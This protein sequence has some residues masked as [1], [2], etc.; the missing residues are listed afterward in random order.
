MRFSPRVL[1]SLGIAGLMLNSTQAQQGLPVSAGSS[2]FAKVG[3][4]FYVQGGA[5]SADNLVPQFFAIDLT[6]SWPA[7]QPSWKSL[8]PGPSNAYHSAGYSADGST[9]FTFG[10]DTGAAVTIV[11]SS[12]LNI[13]NIN[14]GTWTSATPTGL[15]DSTRR[16][17]YAVTNPSANQIYIL[18][19][20]AGAG[21]TIVSNVFDTFNVASGTLTEIT[22]PPSGP[23]NAITYAANI[24]VCSQQYVSYMAQYSAYA[25]GSLVAVFGGFISAAVNAD[26]NAYI[27]NTKTWTWI[28]VPYSGT[29]RGNSAC[30]IVDDTFIIWG[31]YFNN[32]SQTN[33]VP[34]P[35]DALLLLSLST[36]QWLTTYT[37]STN[38]TGGSNSTSSGGSSGTAGGSISSPTNTGASSSKGV[39]TAVIGGIAAGVVVVLLAAAFLLH[40]RNK[41]KNDHVKDGVTNFEFSKDEEGRHEESATHDSYGRPRRPIPPPDELSPALYDFEDPPSPLT[42][43]AQRVSLKNQKEEQRLSI[44]PGYVHAMHQPLQNQNQ[45][46]SLQNQRQPLQNQ[47]QN[48][49]LQTS[50]QMDDAQYSQP[51]VEGYS[52]TVAGYSNYPTPSPV[53]HNAV[54]EP[55]DPLFG[56]ISPY[57]QQQARSYADNYANAGSVY[58]PPPPT[59]LSQQQPGYVKYSTDN[60]PT[61]KVPAE[62]S[63]PEASGYHDSYGMKHQSVYSDSSSNGKRPISGP[64]GG[65][66]FGSIYSPSLPGAPQSIPE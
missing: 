56:G 25:D 15:A 38:M 63:D 16:D 66:G 49:Y 13:F 5:S 26:P 11:P 12:W 35:A 50:P 20:D 54:E 37:P 3:N 52:S 4:S 46:Q 2:A 40:R 57:Q 43:N 21:G 39:P 6:T 1:L 34:A 44:Q 27:L 19:G 30:A 10:R 28:T 48:P 31:G 24:A 22:T 55:T 23:Q 33:G 29:G 62:T 51:S 61:Y 36:Q 41:K 7:S 18:A 14:S 60:Y 53:P 42:A 9:F 47:Y 58:Y 32:P 64:Q 8:A 45:R 59:S 65:P 17:F